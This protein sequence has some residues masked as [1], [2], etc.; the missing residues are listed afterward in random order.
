MKG[1]SDEAFWLIQ[2]LLNKNAEN[3]LG[4]QNRDILAIQ[5]SSFFRGID[6]GKLRNKNL[7]PNLELAMDREGNCVSG[8]LLNASFE[9]ANPQEEFSGYQ[10]GFESDCSKTSLWLEDF[11]QEM[12]T[13]QTSLR[14]L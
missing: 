3:R 6:W 12:Q 2:R 7:P 14:P 8:R 5:Q 9:N 4:S 10:P 1:L 13:Q 11:T